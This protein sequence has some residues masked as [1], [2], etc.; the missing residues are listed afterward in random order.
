MALI[1]TPSRR[2]E[3][4]QGLERLQTP[5]EQKP[6]EPPGSPTFRFLGLC[7]H[8]VVVNRNNNPIVF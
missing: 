3:H 4:P 7:F 8:L 2:Q 1:L 6:A 5:R